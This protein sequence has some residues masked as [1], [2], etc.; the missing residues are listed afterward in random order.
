MR[1]LLL[2]CHSLRGEEAWNLRVYI[3][4]CIDQALIGSDPPLCIL[5]LMH[6]LWLELGKLSF[7]GRR[8]RGKSTGTRCERAAP[9]VGAGGI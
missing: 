9:G 5:I 4:V 8:G 3:Y 1:R 7:G 2:N 6:P